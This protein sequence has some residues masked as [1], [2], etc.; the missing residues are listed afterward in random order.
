MQR[1]VDSN[2]IHAVTTAVEHSDVFTAVRGVV[3]HDLDAEQ[4]AIL[5]KLV[6]RVIIAAVE[7]FA[8]V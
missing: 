1:I 3:Q 4:R 8:R 6:E 5:A 2:R 7:G